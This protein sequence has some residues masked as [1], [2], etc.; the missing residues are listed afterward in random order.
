MKKEP[1]DERRDRVMNDDLYFLPLIADALEQPDPKEALKEAFENIKNLGRQSKFKQGFSQFQRFMN[2]VKS[3]W[4][5]QPQTSE[6]MA[7]KLARDLSHQLAAGLLEDDEKEAKSAMDLIA[8]RPDWKQEFEKLLA[9][10]AGFEAP[11]SAPELIAEK[12][13]ERIGSI[14]FKNQPASK[15]IR[16]LKPGLYTIKLDTGRILWQDRLTENDL[17]WF[18]A[19]PEQDLDLAADTGEA[20]PR[21]T[22]EIR[23]LAGEVIIRVFPEIE[24]GRLELEIRG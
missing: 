2:E 19:F 8:L 3:N 1:R 5:K 17:L 15:T 6:G 7:D 16:N 20:M 21:T 22:L 4:E 18:Y 13:G 14:R 12:E 10:T 24:S 23:L 9:E 11:D